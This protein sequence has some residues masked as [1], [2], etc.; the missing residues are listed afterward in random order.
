M[1]LTLS[2]IGGNVI[3]GGTG[4]VHKRGCTLQK[5]TSTTTGCWAFA[6]TVSRSGIST[7]LNK[8]SRPASICGDLNAGIDN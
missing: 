6:P 3:I 7:T 4:V 8:W 2:T 1:Y 5:Y